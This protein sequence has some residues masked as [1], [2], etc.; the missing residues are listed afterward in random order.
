MARRQAS[1]MRLRRWRIW[2]AS[3]AV[4]VTGAKLR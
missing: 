4:M 1:V 3:R 2:I